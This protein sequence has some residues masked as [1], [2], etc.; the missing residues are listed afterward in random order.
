MGAAER[1][2]KRIPLILRTSGEKVCTIRRDVVRGES[3]G[4]I[5][6]EH[7]GHEPKRVGAGGE[8]AMTPR[9]CVTTNE[10]QDK[11]PRTAGEESQTVFLQYYSR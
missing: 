5:A 1:F 11:E 8:A 7:S 9:I 3:S 6:R 2:S 4:P 10:E